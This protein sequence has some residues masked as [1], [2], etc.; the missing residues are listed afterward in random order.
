MSLRR[1][2]NKRDGTTLFYLHP[3]GWRIKRAERDWD[4]RG[5]GGM[6]VGPKVYWEVKKRSSKSRRTWTFNTLREARKWCDD[7]QPDQCGGSGEGRP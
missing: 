3:N 1:V 7:P 6:T 5:L 4:A 2:R